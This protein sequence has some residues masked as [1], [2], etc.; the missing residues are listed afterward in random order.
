MAFSE[1][2][3]VL[4]EQL[5]KTHIKGITGEYLLKVLQDS[6]TSCEAFMSMKVPK[7][8]HQSHS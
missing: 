6:K 7:C 8:K 5:E 4:N 3:G 2:L 1:V